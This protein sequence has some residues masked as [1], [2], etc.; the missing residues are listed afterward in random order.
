[1]VLGES[2]ERGKALA[3]LL[4]AQ[5]RPGRPKQLL[6]TLIGSANEVALLRSFATVSA[7]L[8]VPALAIAAGGVNISAIT[9]APITLVSSAQLG[10]S[11]VERKWRALAAI[12]QQ[13]V[14]VLFADVNVVLGAEPFALL[15]A[16]SDFEVRGKPSIV[17]S[18]AN[19]FAPR[20]CSF[21]GPHGDL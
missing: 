12:L 10:S 1:M 11:G 21:D 6:V 8:R 18:R 19:Q 20:V 4:A 3:K 9:A 14:H 16:D 13:R 15:A 7:S 5:T 17:I 2:G